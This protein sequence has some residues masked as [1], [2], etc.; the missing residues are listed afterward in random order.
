MVSLAP[1]NGFFGHFGRF[2]GVQG[3]S[4]AQR[5]ILRMAPVRL[6]LLAG[7]TDAPGRQEK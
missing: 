6:K 7:T 2:L 1:Q 5:R 3:R 4:F